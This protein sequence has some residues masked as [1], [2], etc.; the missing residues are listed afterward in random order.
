MSCIPVPLQQCAVCGEELLPSELASI[1]GV[2]VCDDCLSDYCADKA[3]VKNHLEGFLQV[4]E[5]EF[6][7][8]WFSGGEPDDLSFLGDNPVLTE[9]DKLDWHHIFGGAL[10]KKSEQYGLKV[11]LH[12]NRCHIFGPGSAHQSGETA[13][14]LHKAGQ[15]AA[16]REYG[17][18]VEDFRREFYKNYL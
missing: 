8:Y 9:K 14:F 18:T 15:E 5:K 17:W 3:V 11:K 12:H 10:R 1:D 2:F 6:L 13:E 4:K 7:A 16:M